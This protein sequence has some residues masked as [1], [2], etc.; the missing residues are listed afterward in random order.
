MSACTQRS[1]PG[2]VTLRYALW[3]TPTVVALHQQVIEEFE[4]THPGIDVQID[5]SSWASYWDKLQVQLASNTGPDVF[6]MSGAYYFNFRDEDTFLNL[7]PLLRRDS[8]DL[9]R[10][11][12]QQELFKDSTRIFGLPKD[13]TTVVLYYNKT[14]FDA[15]RVAYPDASWTWDDYTTAAHLL[16]KDRDGDG[17]I[18]QWGSATL[19]PW[20]E[21][22]VAPLVFSNGGTL[23][24]ADRTRCL[25]DQ[26]EAV[27]AIQFMVDLMTV[28]KVCPGLGQVVTV[29]GDA[30]STGQVGMIQNISAMIPDY[31]KIRAFEWDIA[32]IPKSPHTNARV[33]TSGGMINV[34]NARTRH[35]AESWELTKYLSSEAAERLLAQ[36]K[37]FAVSLKHIAD[38]VFAVP[39]PVHIKEVLR[40]YDYS[41][42]LQFTRNW[43][44]WNSI[45]QRELEPAFLG[46]VSVAEACAAAARSVNK[47]LESP[48]EK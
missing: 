10:H 29:A 45:V 25:L 16:T 15:A 5:A 12:L 4:K 18:D 36:Q 35:P 39:P 28:H 44:E 32:P 22:Y 17:S 46:R 27:Q 21:E 37:T 7:A 24:N 11:F 38:S 8:L 19:M 41:H 43:I 48:R 33:T 14:M 6:W 31:L 20:V 47:V 2:K 26:P 9:S 40:A 23:L 30:F 1:T 34:I 42:D 3:G 13:L